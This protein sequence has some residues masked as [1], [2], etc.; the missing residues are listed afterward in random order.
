LFVLSREKHFSQSLF[1][2]IAELEGDITELNGTV[3]A[4]P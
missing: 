1:A 2:Q 3:S 4:D